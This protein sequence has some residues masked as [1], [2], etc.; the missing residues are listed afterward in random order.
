MIVLDTHAWIWWRADPG[1]L[2]APAA[3][4]IVAADRIGLSAVSVWELGMLVRLGRIS[5]DRDVARWVRHALADGQEAE[6]VESRT[7]A[8]VG[9]SGADDRSRL[10]GFAA[11]RRLFEGL[12]SL[13]PVILV[14]EDVHWADEGLLEFIDNLAACPAE[15]LGERKYSRRNRPGRMNDRFQVRVIE[16]ERVRGDAVEQRGARHVDPFAPAQHCGR[17]RLMWWKTTR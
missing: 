3:D 1:R 2:S 13:R 11:W 5:L 6:W 12:A 8:L 14:F 9:L 17:E 16:V 15:V 4:V 7:R 10:E